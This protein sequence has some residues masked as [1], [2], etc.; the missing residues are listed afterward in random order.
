MI[1]GTAFAKINFGLRVGSRRPDGFHPVDGIFQSVNLADRLT[2]TGAE[3]DTIGTSGGASV[4]EGR[5]NLAFKAVAA[6][7]E[8]AGSSRP[9]AVT[10]DKSIPHASGLG[11]G[12]ADAAIALVIA[13]LFFDVQ[14]DVLANIAPQLGSDVPFCLQGGTARVAGRGEAVVRMDP[15]EGF[16]LG[17]VV[18]PVDVSTPEVFAAWDD[19]NEPEGLRSPASGLPPSLRGEGELVNDLYPASI[20]VAP[21][22]DDWRQE[23]ESRW[24][25][26]V[27]LSGSGPSLFGFFLDGDEAE[28]AIGIAP[29]GARLAEAIDLSPVGWAVAD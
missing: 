25:R 11:G 23:L 17:L 4:L 20:A 8:H 26:L 9:V 5:N 6:V 1:S 15:L 24:G 7:R 22:V 12:S 27:M 19:L 3:H 16:S 29:K 10:L 14:P 18:P 21:A 13:G 28:D 2:L